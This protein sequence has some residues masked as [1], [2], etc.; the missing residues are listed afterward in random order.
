MD[1]VRMQKAIDTL[2]QVHT[3]GKKFDIDHWVEDCMTPYDCGTAACSLGWIA[4]SEWANEIGLCLSANGSPIYDGDYTYN[5]AEKFF[6]IST[7]QAGWLF[8]PFEYENVSN[9]ITT[10]MHTVNRMKY[11]LANPNHRLNNEKEEEA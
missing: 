4:R 2:T 8:D 3:L 9:E 7:N 5:A 1:T 10:A 11:L 6:D